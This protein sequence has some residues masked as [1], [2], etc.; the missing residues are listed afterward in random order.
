MPLISAPLEKSIE[1]AFMAQS[2]PAVVANKLATAYDNYCKG[3]LAGGVPPLL[4]GAEVKAMEGILLAAIAS[5]S[6]SPAIFAAAWTAALQAYW[7]A[8][9]VVFSA[10]PIT[11][12]ATVMPGAGAVTP[13]LTA[14][15]SNTLNTEG[16]IAKLIASI[17]GAATKTVLV[18]FSTPTPPA[19]PPPPATVV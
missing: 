3:G 19:G 11:G 6:G 8:P 9:P 17:I 4:T 10:P 1:A 2:S 5:P 16:I 15:F 12:V 13:A 7:L 14:A 18:T